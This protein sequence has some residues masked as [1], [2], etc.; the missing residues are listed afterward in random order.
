MREK[1][2]LKKTGVIVNCLTLIIL[3]G[4]Y[5]S[6]LLIYNYSSKTC[7]LCAPES[8]TFWDSFYSSVNRNRNN[9]CIKEILG[10]LSDAHGVLIQKL[11]C[12]KW[13]KILVI[14]IIIIM[15]FWSLGNMLDNCI[16]WYFY[17]TNMW[18]Y[19]P[20]SNTILFFNICKY[21]WFN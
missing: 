18:M 2:T 8:Q 11:T 16:P 7:L 5:F 13:P 17:K 12:S 4:F 21:N 10:G 1:L 3:N 20:M 19:F 9:N 6:F 14:I 15:V